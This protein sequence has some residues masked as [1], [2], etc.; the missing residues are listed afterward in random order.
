MGTAHNKNLITFDAHPS[1]ELP[2]SVRRPH[3]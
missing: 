1:R 2:H 3:A